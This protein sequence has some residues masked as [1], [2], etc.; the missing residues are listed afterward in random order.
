M[1]P[2]PLHPLELDINAGSAV[3]WR[4]DRQGISLLITLFGDVDGVLSAWSLSDPSRWSRYGRVSG[5][6]FIVMRGVG[7]LGLSYQHET[8]VSW[9]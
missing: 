7:D 2:H 5:L 3:S 9:P 6:Y 8:D 4:S 1:K